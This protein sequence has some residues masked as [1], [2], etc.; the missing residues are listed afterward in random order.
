MAFLEYLDLYYVNTPRLY[1]NGPLTFI[2]RIHNT[3]DAALAY[4]KSIKFEYY[5][6]GR[7][8]E[9]TT[10]LKYAVDN[11][12][13]GRANLAPS[14]WIDYT[15]T[16]RPGANTVDMDSI[17]LDQ[18]VT[19]NFVDSSYIRVARVA[20]TD[21]Y[22]SSTFN[23]HPL[24]DMYV[25]PHQQNPMIAF[26][27]APSW[28]RISW[29]TTQ[30][31]G[32]GTSGQGDIP[33]FI[34]QIPGATTTVTVIG[35]SG[36]C[37]YV[38]SVF[39]IHMQDQIL[40]EMEPTLHVCDE[41]KPISLSVLSQPDGAVFYTVRLQNQEYRQDS[42]VNILPPL[43]PG[44]YNATIQAHTVSCESVEVPFQ[45]HVHPRPSIVLESEVRVCSTDLSVSIPYLRASDEIT[46]CRV[47]LNGSILYQGQLPPERITLPN[48]LTPD[49]VE[50]SITVE[51]NYCVSLP[52][53]L[54]VV[55]VQAPT[56]SS[57]TFTACDHNGLF[58]F[59][60]PVVGEAIGWTIEADSTYTG[61]LTAPDYSI[62]L[63]S[64]VTGGN[65]R[66]IGRLCSGD[67]VPFFIVSGNPV[68]IG[69]T[70]ISMCPGEIPL[71]FQPLDSSFS[72]S[73]SGDPIGVPPSGRGGIL[74]TTSA[75]RGR[76]TI[77]PEHRGC[78]GEPLEIQV[79]VESAP[80]VESVGEI[81]AYLGQN[82]EI[83]LSMVAHWRIDGLTG[84]SDLVQLIPD[85]V[86]T[87]TIYAFA[88]GKCVTDE[89]PIGAITVLESPITFTQRVF[90]STFCSVGQIIQYT[91]LIRNESDYD[92][93]IVDGPVRAL[94]HPGETVTEVVDY[95]VDME[96][97]TIGHIVDDVQLLL[98][99][100]TKP[101]RSQ[102]TIT[103]YNPVL[104]Q[105]LEDK[106][107][108]VGESFT[109][110]LE[111]A[112]LLV[113]NDHVAVDA[114]T[115]QGVSAGLSVITVVLREG[116]CSSSA[117]F[118]VEVL[119][120]LDD[121]VACVGD[122]VQVALERS[123]SYSGAPIGIAV[124]GTDNIDFNAISAGSGVV[125][126]GRT[127]FT[128][129]VS[130]PPNIH[131]V[132]DLIQC[133]GQPL[134]P[135]Q[136]IGS[137]ITSMVLSVSGDY[138][139]TVTMSLTPFNEHCEGT[140]Q[141]FNLTVVPLP[142]I[143]PIDDI[144]LWIGETTTVPVSTSNYSLETTDGPIGPV[145]AT[146]KGVEI[147]AEQVGRIQI[148]LTPHNDLC[149]GRPVTF[150]VIVKALPTGSISYNGLVHC[151]TGLL[152]P[153]IT[154][155]D[156]PYTL[157]SIPDGLVFIG[158]DIDLQS[159]APGLYRVA[160]DAGVVTFESNSFFVLNCPL[161]EVDIM[162]AEIRGHYI[163]YTVRIKNVSGIDVDHAQF[164][165]SVVSSAAQTLSLLAD[166]EQ[167]L[168]YRHTT[169][170]GRFIV[171]NEARISW[172]EQCVYDTTI[173][174]RGKPIA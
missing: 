144:I 3:S 161:F 101:Y 109:L 27:A 110:D 100:F 173:V 125:V 21:I 134:G 70:S 19:I 166:E 20:T 120:K 133:A 44:L 149:S 99:G 114:T 135:I 67:F 97:M 156:T 31:I 33:S 158:D 140:T 131:P 94:L 14:Q 43:A 51:S 121:V 16:Y 90:P 18:V 112:T 58:T 45:L 77:I 23:Y 2:L 119:Q 9:Q 32:F 122:R 64:H 26:D 150:T 159:S 137:N 80:V 10:Q 116:P 87:S 63:P 30:D 129:T 65:I 139:G 75:G 153:N 22:N 117:T 42:L 60:L 35:A 47:Q 128:I 1:C 11:V 39:N 143:E 59:S 69:P 76:L 34:G 148:A 91:Y 169:S 66:L 172:N 46:S 168:Q 106:T 61:T 6:H 56:L 170:P 141:T 83:P 85:R 113:N 152:T 151:R 50:L 48:T 107:I 155:Q 98:E 126:V 162:S 8:G 62:D 104:I 38:H 105:P 81:I 123:W 17:Y 102:S 127:S 49:V 40:L 89:S 164:T 25:C 82:V 147:V 71:E 136:I 52:I 157:R 118:A 4:Y 115:I 86:G 54:P 55:Y 163:N 167:V 93:K 92:L 108:Y 13:N 78:T 36:S 142:V 111:H 130:E 154:L 124:T 165:D 41:E 74:Y 12:D 7:K 29:T 5:I 68:V 24:G 28:A 96:D 73:Y 79:T 146:T 145:T 160:L 72:W 138:I 171:Q 95:T 88:D 132:A 57:T 37:S 15:W 103:Y 53:E 84:N 174:S